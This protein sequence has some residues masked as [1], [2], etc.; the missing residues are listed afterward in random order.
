MTCVGRNTDRR[1]FASGTSDH[2][3]CSR[4]MEAVTAA[5]IDMTCDSWSQPRVH[6]RW[7]HQVPSLQHPSPQLPSLPHPLPLRQWIPQQVCCVTT[8]RFVSEQH[9]VA[10]KE[11]CGVSEQTLS[12]RVRFEVQDESRISSIS[13]PSYA[14][15]MLYLPSE[16]IFTKHA[17]VLCY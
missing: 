15:F 11:T 7:A 17:Y 13:V 4:Q 1:K 10:Q 16:V 9:R 6:Q 3:A 12:V 8:C 2:P 14:W 5:A